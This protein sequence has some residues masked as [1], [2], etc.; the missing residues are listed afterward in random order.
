MLIRLSLPQREL[1][2]SKKWDLL[3]LSWSLL[4]LHHIPARQNFCN[5]SQIKPFGH[6]Q[7]LLQS[8]LRQ[9]SHHRTIIQNRHFDV[10]LVHLSQ[11]FST[12]SILLPV[13]V[14]SNDGAFSHLPLDK[15]YWK[16]QKTLSSCEDNRWQLQK[17]RNQ[18]SLARI[19]FWIDSRHLQRD[20]ILL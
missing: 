7:F 3:V 14:G 10:C 1:R 13:P 18:T 20:K 9:C 19:H 2:K 6:T 4:V 12:L 11:G 8:L 16:I 15:Q 17:P 5:A